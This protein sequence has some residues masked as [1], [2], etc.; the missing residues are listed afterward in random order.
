MFI[1]NKKFY[2]STTVGEKGQ[3]VLPADLR[4]DL[5]VEAGDKLAV[6]VL[7]KSGFSGIVMIQTGLLTVI[8]E[9]FFGGKLAEFIKDKKSTEKVK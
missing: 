2:G 6:L 8:L 5:K 3:V 1:D 9:K 7:K 4:R